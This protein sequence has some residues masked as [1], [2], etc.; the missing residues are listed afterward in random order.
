MISR[1]DLLGGAAIAFLATRALWESV[2]PV[3]RSW[4]LMRNFGRRCEIFFR[5][6]QMS[7]S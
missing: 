3:I 6:I 4:S 5:S 2:A 1:R 7:F